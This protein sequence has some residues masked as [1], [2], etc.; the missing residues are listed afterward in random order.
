VRGCKSGGSGLPSRR[1][2]RSDEAG[3][4][5]WGVKPFTRNGTEYVGSSDPDY[6]LVIFE[7]KPWRKP[8]VGRCVHGPVP[9]LCH[10]TGSRVTTILPLAL[11]CST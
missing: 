3:N 5:F 11:P 8:V 9:P 6:G 7:Y 1:D 10:A 2:R 4:N